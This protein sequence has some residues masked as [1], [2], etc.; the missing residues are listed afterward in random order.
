MSVSLPAAATTWTSSSTQ[1]SAPNAIAR[2]TSDAGAQSHHQQ[3]R[4]RQRAERG[5]HL[6]AVEGREGQVDEHDVGGP[7]LD[8]ELD[9]V[10]VGND[11]RLDAGIGEGDGDTV[12]HVG[13]ALYDQSHACACASPP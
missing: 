6:P 11:D 10:A 3:R 4:L 12:G 8:L 2:T 1:A 7:R 5:E 13:T 9:L